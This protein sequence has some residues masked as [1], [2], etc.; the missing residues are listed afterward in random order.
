MEILSKI[1]AGVQSNES[2]ETR[3]HFQVTSISS[4]LILIFKSAEIC[5]NFLKLSIDAQSIDWFSV[6]FFHKI[7]TEIRCKS[8]RSPSTCRCRSS[9]LI[10]TSRLRSIQ[11]IVF[12]QCSAYRNQKSLPKFIAH[13]HCLAVARMQSSVPL[14]RVNN[15]SQIN[16]ED[17]R[18]GKL[19]ITLPRW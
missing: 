19:W 9:L 12:T 17:K 5:I 3:Q 10:T 16:G 8:L 7:F 11:W 1:K 6:K 2:F 14:D 15:L 4:Q 13:Q 18:I